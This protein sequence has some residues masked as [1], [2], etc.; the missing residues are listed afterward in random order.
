MLR[1]V[2]NPNPSPDPY[3]EGPQPQNEPHNQPQ[4]Q[5][6]GERTTSYTSQP[7]L[8]QAS[9]VESN[10]NLPHATSVATALPPTETTSDQRSRPWQADEDSNQQSS[11]NE[12]TVSDLARPPRSSSLPPSTIFVSQ[13]TSTNAGANEPVEKAV[14]GET[15]IFLHTTPEAESYVS[16][17]QRRLSDSSSNQTPTQADFTK[18]GPNV[19]TS[20]SP[21]TDDKA[22]SQEQQESESSEGPEPTLSL[23]PQ[24]GME[25]EKRGI[26]VPHS[27]YSTHLLP[28]M[29]KNQAEPKGFSETEPS[30]GSEPQILLQTSIQESLPTSASAGQA[31]SDAPMDSTQVTPRQGT[32]NDRPTRPFSFMEI[33]ESE[34][35]QRPIEKSQREPSVSSNDGRQFYDRP[36]SPVS[37]QR[38]ITRE[39]SDMH[40]QDQYDPHRSASRPLQDPNISNHPAYRVSQPRQDPHPS[41]EHYPGRTTREDARLQRQHIIDYRPEGVGPTPVSQS[42]PT[43]SRSRRGSRSST[44]FRNLAKS[45]EP[46]L[47]TNG[48]DQVQLAAK[49]PNQATAPNEGK[50]SK[51][52]SVFRTLTGRSGGGDRDS[53]RE[54]ISEKTRVVPQPKSPPR[55]HTPT[56]PPPPPSNNP[57]VESSTSSKV[58]SKKLQR[59]STSV[60]PEKK[61]GGKKKRFSTIGVNSPPQHRT[62]SSDKCLQFSRA[63]YFWTLA[64]KVRLDAN[65]RVPSTSPSLASITSIAVLYP[66]PRP[67]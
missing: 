5:P 21:L 54:S 19:Q 7:I 45:E 27:R 32:S 30:I 65:S 62:N 10:S 17:P 55:K 28:S 39:V 60:V 57:R 51:R 20:S 18:P 40:E 33:S 47:P 56:I 9:S 36:P 52:N 23:G 58:K 6:H 38:S 11:K 41:F 50:R 43:A 37:P 53:N 12:P 42:E 61:D 46:P 2:T 16:S 15:P 44:F 64:R 31:V 48:S 1:Q 25:N 14:V 24:R 66:P 13:D 49:S 3:S 8:Q 63:E 35:N 29:D 34:A 26:T 4:H 67:Q 59:A 22:G